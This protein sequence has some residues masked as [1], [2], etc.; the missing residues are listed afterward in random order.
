MEA[1]TKLKLM[2]EIRI[3]LSVFIVLLVLNGVTAFPLET[4]LNILVRF[5]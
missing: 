2:K 4:E 1:L 3:M 5:K